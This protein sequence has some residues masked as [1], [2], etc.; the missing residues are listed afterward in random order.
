MQQ[1]CDKGAAGTVQSSGVAYLE[2]KNVS[3]VF[4]DQKRGTAL[5]TLDGINL[6]LAQQEFLCLLGP[7]GCGKSTLLNMIAG[8]ETATSGS[9]RVGE[10]QVSKPGA[11]RGMVFQQPTLMPWLPVW[12]NIAFHYK[13]KGKSAAQRRELSQ[14]FID[15]V[16]LRGFENHYPTEL[17]GGMSQRVGIARAL[18]MNPDVVLMDEPFA[19]LDAQT[20]EEIQEALVTIWQQSRSTIVFVTHSIDEAL[21]LGTKVAV[22]T[23]RPGRIRE[24]ISVDLPRPRDITSPAFNDLKRHVHALIREEASAARQLLRE[25]QMA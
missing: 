15:M 8:F 12:D 4:T 25:E 5:T 14:T 6:D 21:L 18:L 7:S 13:L 24:L 9:V 10:K 1:H 3:K 20:K 16:G 17:S 2:I 11:E 19:A 23:H 22:M